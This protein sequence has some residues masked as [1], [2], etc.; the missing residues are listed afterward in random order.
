MRATTCISLEAAI[1]GS[2]KG[3][4]P[5]AT[6]LTGACWAS[7]ARKSPDVTVL[8]NC[9]ASMSPRSLKRSQPTLAIDCV[10]SNFFLLV[11]I[12]IPVTQSDPIFKV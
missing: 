10:I 5:S 7:S 4:T 9:T 12:S 2:L 3:V 11:A 8:G 6:P 1:S